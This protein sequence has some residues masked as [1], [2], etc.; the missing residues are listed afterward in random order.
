MSIPTLKAISYTGLKHKHK[1]TSQPSH[2]TALRP[3]AKQPLQ[4]KP[5]S[6]SKPVA[7]SIPP[8]PPV[9]H[10][11]L[12]PKASANCANET[13]AL[14]S[15]SDGLT[16]VAIDASDVHPVFLRSRDS[17][18]TW[19]SLADSYWG[20]QYGSNFSI[21]SS[22]NGSVLVATSVD[23]IYMSNNSGATWAHTGFRF[24]EFKSVAISGDG[25]RVFA[26]GISGIYTTLSTGV[27]WEYSPVTVTLDSTGW[28]AITSSSDG[29]KIVALQ[30]GTSGGS[31]YTSRRIM[32]GQKPKWLLAGTGIF[33]QWCRISSRRQWR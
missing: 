5:V 12:Y 13:Q 3:T 15:S 18:A 32:A 24:E 25:F 30:G 28:Q 19:L 21:A 7:Q 33:Q 16:L 6:S 27:R 9:Q 11:T 22:A 23:Y 31:I 10:H 29:I 8:A 20:L 14:A 4:K 2:A 26:A 17:G 1:P